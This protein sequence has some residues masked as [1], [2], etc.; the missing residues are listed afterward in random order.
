MTKRKYEPQQKSDE[1]YVS[2]GQCWEHR[3]TESPSVCLNDFYKYFTGM[4]YTKC[5]TYSLPKLV[6][7]VC[8][9][10]ELSY[11]QVIEWVHLHVLSPRYYILF[12]GGPAKIGC[13][14]F[15]LQ[16]IA[17]QSNSF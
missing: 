4:N 7:L 13:L 16:I 14:I 5:S 3:R 6:M 15:I 11:G 1:K 10:G 8:N 17:L 12:S 9:K 2:A